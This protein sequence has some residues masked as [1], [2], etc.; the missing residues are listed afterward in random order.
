MKD[1]FKK[2]PGLI[3]FIGVGILLTIVFVFYE[4]MYN[5]QNKEQQGQYEELN[6]SAWITEV[7]EPEES[8]TFSA[9]DAERAEND[10]KM[11]AFLESVENS[12]FYKKQLKSRPNFETYW[13][14]NEDVIGY[15]L[16]PDSKIEYPILQNDSKRDY[17]LKRNI[18]GSTGYPGCIYIE[19]INEPN[20]RDPV[21]IAY[22]HNMANK[23]MFGQLHDIYRNAAF[24][25]SHKYVFVYQP[26][27]VSLYEI[28]A[29][30]SYSDEHLLA[31]N[32]KKEDDGFMFTGIRQDDQVK[33]MNHLKEYGDKNAYFKEGEEVTENDRLFVMATCS[34]NR[35]RVIVVGKLLFTHLY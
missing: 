18:D 27:S 21:T 7:G 33:V 13:E 12:D 16:I 34:S 35:I 1:F 2:Y 23:T 9:E 6:K 25:D 32:F 15:L 20:F 24:R 17:Y 29:A 26:E 22:G 8:E 4:V 19:N 5:T 3:V 31:D 30:T 11:K 10:A 14:I 28:I